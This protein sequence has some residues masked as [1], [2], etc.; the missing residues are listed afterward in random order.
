MAVYNIN[1][2]PVATES[3][4]LTN[5]GDITTASGF[6]TAFNAAMADEKINGILIPFGTYN[7]NS[8]LNITR[9]DFTIDGCGCTLNMRSDDGQP[10]AADCFAINNKRRIVIKNFL[11]NMRQN[12][13]STAGTT[14]YFLDANQVT[15]ENI[16]VYQI[17]CRGAL[18]YNT[19]DTSATPGSTK[20]F[21]K[22][23][24]LRGIDAQNTTAS[25]WPCGIIAV[26]LIDSGFEDCVVS[27]MCRFSLEFK[28][29][30]KNSYMINNIIY[31]G[32]LTS[33][34]E[35]GIALGG[36][37]PASESLLSDGIVFIGNVVRNCKFPLYI[38]RVANSVF[39]DNVFEGQIYAESL[40][41][42]VI[43]GNNIKSS[44]KY[45][46]PL[47][48]LSGC[49]NVLMA[50]NLYDP[51]QNDLF[52]IPTSNTNVLVQGYMNGREINVPNPTS[53]TPS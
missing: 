25:E 6:V 44:A 51:E 40:N 27:G 1:G 32:S 18:I 8:R 12:V 53:G 46:I 26:N 43:N 49:E 4:L 17:G 37:R 3:A 16:D 50:E 42:C 30:T 10:V 41:G 39:N 33:E 34:N 28:N 23:V 35:S 47:I 31:G 29:Y 21:F 36:D 2:S 52:I 45:N 19:D 7:I 5:Y 15:V 9:N 38:G 11:I 22:N 20:I 13:N 48:R 24:K 14:F